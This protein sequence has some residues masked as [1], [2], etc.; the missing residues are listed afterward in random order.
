MDSGSVASAATGGLGMARALSITPAS[1]ASQTTTNLRRTLLAK[2]RGQSVI[3]AS[4]P[5]A[6]M[7]SPRC[8]TFNLDTMELGETDLFLSAP[9][10]PEVRTCV[11]ARMRVCVCARTCVGSHMCALAR[12][13]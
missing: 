2:A 5:G 11:C 3:G 10:Y 4:M 8:T 1:S 13:W 12:L 6:D 7:R 9:I